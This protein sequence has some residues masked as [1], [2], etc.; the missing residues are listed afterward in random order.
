MEDFRNRVNDL[1]NSIQ[2]NINIEEI[3]QYLQKQHSEEKPVSFKYDE[4]VDDQNSFCI[5][6]YYKS[7]G[8]HSDIN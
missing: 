7:N 1:I 2:D 4:A 3:D 5:S 6:N 8:N